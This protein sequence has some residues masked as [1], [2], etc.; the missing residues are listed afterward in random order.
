[1]ASHEWQRAKLADICE[2][3]FDCPHSTPKLTTAG[4]LVA[5]SQDIRSGFFR[6]EQAAH[7]SEETYR[8]RIARAE[9]RHGDLLYSREGTY[10]GIAAEVPAGVRVCLGQ[11]MVLIRPMPKYVHSK[12][13]RYWLNSPEMEAY[14]YGFRDGSVAE[15]LNLP[16]IRQL[17]VALPPLPEQ[18]TIARI[19]GALDD[20]IELNRRMNRTLEAMAAALFKSW[21]VDFD[22]VVAKAEGRPPFGM[23]A[24]T[25]AL[26]PSAFQ[27]SAIGPIPQGWSVHPV[28]NLVRAV[29][30]ATPNTRQPSYWDGGTIAWATPKDLAGLNDSVLLATERKI[31]EAG[32]A[33]IGSGLLPA[34]TVLMSSRAPVGY[35]AI[36]EI[37]IAVNQGFIAMV[38][39]DRL[40]NYYMFHWLRE[41]MEM[42]VSRANGTTFLEIS[43][44]NFR[45]IPA[46]KPS[47]PIIQCFVEI[48]GRLHSKIVANVRESQTL[49]ALRDTLLPKLLSSE[50]R[51]RQAEA[52]VNEL[53]GVPQDGSP[54]RQRN[55][56]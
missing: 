49:T 19:L 15:R 10:F 4:P 32:L 31:T 50:L 16:T 42:I 20:K 1:M 21:F 30:G 47:Q 9:P 27:E 8:E 54:S 48:V 46:L 23:N 56:I 5:R 53:S 11:R 34:G 12:Y 24:E 51:L 13:L 29:G 39:D 52:L 7:V 45:P 25:A 28:G 43:K 55:G 18:Q 26:F 40:P 38:C 14:V 37:A 36:S 6:A 17:P 22:P 35:L 44:S 33:Q 2:G 41:N 3:I